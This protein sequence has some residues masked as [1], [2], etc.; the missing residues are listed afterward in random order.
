LQPTSGAGLDP[1][2]SDVHREGKHQQRERH[3]RD[4][5]RGCSVE[6]PCDRSAHQLEDRECQQQCD[7]QRTKGLEFGVAIR[8]I[9][10]GGFRRHSHHENG[11]E[12]VGRVDC[13]LESIAEDGQGVRVDADR[14]LDQH[15]DDVGHQDPAKH[16]AHS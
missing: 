2:H 8:V 5:Q 14:E 7:E 6:E 12:I 15:H 4:V 11:K 10:V 3:A 16:P 9:L 13:R 1:D